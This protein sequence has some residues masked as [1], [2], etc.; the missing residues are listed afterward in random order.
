MKGSFL[1]N[2]IRYLSLLHTILG[3]QVCA[4]VFDHADVPGGY[5]ILAVINLAYSFLAFLWFVANCSE[6]D[7]ERFILDQKTLGV[8]LEVVFALLG[9]LLLGA[10]LLEMYIYHEDESYQ[11]VHKT[12]FLLAS[13]A[14][15]ISVALITALICFG[16]QTR[17]DDAKAASK[18]L[19]EGEGGQALMKP[20]NRSYL[21]KMKSM[22]KPTYVIRNSR[23]RI[24]RFKN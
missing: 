24:G 6:G 16:N 15:F 8:K 7:C 20:Y 11:F 18:N 3:L 10:L 22:P 4:D 13:I 1:L 23:P 14:A 21:T 12:I 2:V 5:G 17:K 19:E 9:R